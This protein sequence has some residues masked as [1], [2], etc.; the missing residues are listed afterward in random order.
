ML[1]FVS[2]TQSKKSRKALPWGLNNVSVDSGC[3]GYLR[4]LVALSELDTR[5]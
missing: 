1:A 3:S 5:S 2:R 4:L